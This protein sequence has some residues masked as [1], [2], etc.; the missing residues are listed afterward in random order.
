MVC[1]LQEIRAHKDQLVETVWVLKK[2]QMV[3]SVSQETLD[4][5]EIRELKVLQVNMVEQMK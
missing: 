5:Q 4:L 2:V 3:L 1:I